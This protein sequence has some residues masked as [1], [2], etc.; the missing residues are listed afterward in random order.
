MV[1]PWLEEVEIKRKKSEYLYVAIITVLQS[2]CSHTIGI[3]WAILCSVYIRSL[4]HTHTNAAHRHRKTHVS[5]HMHIVL[6][7]FVWMY[8]FDIWQ[9]KY[10]SFHKH[11]YSIFDVCFR[12]QSPHHI[13]TNQIDWTDMFNSIRTHTLNPIR[14]NWTLSFLMSL[15]LRIWFIYF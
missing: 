14:F 9:L 13:K 11:L 7:G 1:C 6:Y 10:T 8:L 2:V 4:T 3:M 15:S 5:L 12:F